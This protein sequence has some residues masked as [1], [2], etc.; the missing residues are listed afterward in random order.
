MSYIIKL[1]EERAACEAR[2]K[3]LGMVNR[4]AGFAEAAAADARYQLA[5]DAYAKADQDYRIAIGGMSAA[6]LAALA[7]Q[8][9]TK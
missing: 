1:A 5:K 2:M 3:Y 7:D 9:S 6:E 4:P 8:P